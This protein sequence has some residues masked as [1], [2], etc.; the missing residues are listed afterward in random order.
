MSDTATQNE[1]KSETKAAKNYALVLWND[2]VNTI[3]DVVDAIVDICAYDPIQAEQCATM[4]HYK[5]KY[6]MLSGEAFAA[7]YKMKRQFDHRQI[8]TTIE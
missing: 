4:A 3:D 8:N 2:D 5:G 6:A 1:E 7:L